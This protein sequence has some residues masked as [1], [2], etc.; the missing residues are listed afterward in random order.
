MHSSWE[1][2]EEEGERLGESDCPLDTICRSS[3]Q[4]N[5]K[6]SLPLSHSLSSLALF[7]QAV[8]GFLAFLK[9]LASKPLSPLS[10]FSSVSLCLQKGGIFIS[11]HRAQKNVRIKTGITKAGA[12]PHWSQ[13]RCSFMES[14][15]SMLRYLSWLSIYFLIEIISI[16][17]QEGQSWLRLWK[18]KIII[19]NKQRWSSSGEKLI[20]MD[21]RATDPK[22]VQ[23]AWL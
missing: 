18:G 19:F 17:S 11:C 21:S 13:H 12:S 16:G 20:V 6:R 7:L 22:S 2:V 23:P 9:L 4:K 15:Q 14:L 5:L 8:S 10:F 1:R 3:H